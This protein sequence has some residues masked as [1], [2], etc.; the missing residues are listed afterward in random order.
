MSRNKG[1]KEAV[2]DEIKQVLK[3]RVKRGVKDDSKPETT[4]E[5][6][7]EVTEDINV[8]MNGRNDPIKIAPINQPSNNLPAIPFQAETF[9]PANLPPELESGWVAPNADD[10]FG[11]LVLGVVVW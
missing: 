10:E 1:D 8:S 4:E 3:N 2:K 6:K 11:W 7:V 9:L 5:A